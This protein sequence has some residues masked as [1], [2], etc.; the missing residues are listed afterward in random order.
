MA[1]DRT[2]HDLGVAVLV[3]G[4]MLLIV[5]AILVALMVAGPA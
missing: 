3:V 4:G 2:S 5:V 1:S